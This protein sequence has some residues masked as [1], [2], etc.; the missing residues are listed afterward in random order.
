[1]RKTIYVSLMRLIDVTGALM[2][3]ALVVS[4]LRAE[5]LANELQ[6]THDE[7]SSPRRGAYSLE[8]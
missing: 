6:W 7:R 5:R 1:M 8:D 2:P 3:V 4:I